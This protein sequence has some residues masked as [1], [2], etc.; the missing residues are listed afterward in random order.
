MTVTRLLADVAGTLA[1]HATPLLVLALF[2]A[3]AAYL[4]APA[5]AT[6]WAG[7]GLAAFLAHWLSLRL[8]LG[9]PLRPGAGTAPVAGEGARLALSLLLVGFILAFLAIMTLLAVT[10]AV[11]AVMAG[12]GFDFDASA[13]GGEAARAAMDAFRAG[14]G[15]QLAQAIGLVGASLFAGAVARALPAAATSLAEGRVVAM[16]AF[17]RTRGRTVIL[18]AALLVTLAPAI[19]LMIAAALAPDAVR[20]LSAAATGLAVPLSALLSAAVWRAGG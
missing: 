16:E 8:A 15:W 19:A 4:A 6:G 18:L 7:A 3:G 1:R 2:V 12:A 11:L 13:E 10:L 14:P 5:G 9:Q 17:H 20:T